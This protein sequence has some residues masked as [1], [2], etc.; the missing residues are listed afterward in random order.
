MY[1]EAVSEIRRSLMEVKHDETSSRKSISY[2]VL[3]GSRAHEAMLCEVEVQGRKAAA[4]RGAALVGG[5][6][7]L[8]SLRHH[9]KRN[10]CDSKISFELDL[11]FSLL[12]MYVKFYRYHSVITFTQW[13]E[14]MMNHSFPIL[15]S[16]SKMP[17]E[18][19]ITNISFAET[20]SPCLNGCEKSTDADLLHEIILGC[21]CACKTK[22]ESETSE[23]CAEENA[24]LH[25]PLAKEQENGSLAENHLKLVLKRT[26]QIGRKQLSRAPGTL[27]RRLTGD[28]SEEKLKLSVSDDGSSEAENLH[29]REI[30]KSL[31][32]YISEQSDLE[33]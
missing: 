10:S 24:T 8:S 26:L 14:A 11:L 21:Y 32:C 25:V 9:A 17:N 31:H 2:K 16:F 30:A 19:N 13:H 3:P 7:I 18:R 4:L 23:N 28:T 33:W 1:S 15:Q 22:E 29:W 12:E 20:S 6:G 5:V 27:R